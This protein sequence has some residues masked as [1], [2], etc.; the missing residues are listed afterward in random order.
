MPPPV[1]DAPA[2]RPTTP[3]KETAVSGYAR[4]EGI[5]DTVRLQLNLPSRSMKY[6]RKPNPSDDG[7]EL[8]AIYQS[9]PMRALELSVMTEDE[10]LKLKEFWNHAC[11]D[12]LETVRE[13]D[14]AAK[15]RMERDRIPSKRLYRTRSQLVVFPADESEVPYE[16]E[17][18]LA[19]E[20]R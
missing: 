7:T 13:L 2:P 11:D 15:E 9:K 6:E 4:Y 8:H 17:P 1:I 10:L 14:R 20:D 18:A 3:Q 16:W 19:G 12:A 5:K